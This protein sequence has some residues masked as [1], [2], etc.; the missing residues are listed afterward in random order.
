MLKWF[1]WKY[2]EQGLVLGNGLRPTWLETGEVLSLGPT[3][4]RL[5]PISVDAQ[6]REEGVEVRWQGD[7][8]EDAPSI[9]VQL[10]GRETAEPTVDQSRVIVAPEAVLA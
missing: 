6:T 4:T 10:P 2:E 8:R 3:P 5:G 1:P 9:L 7:W